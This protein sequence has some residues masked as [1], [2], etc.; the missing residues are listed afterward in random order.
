MYIENL[1]YVIPARGVTPDNLKIKQVVDDFGLKIP[2][3]RQS[4]LVT[5]IAETRKVLLDA[6]DYYQNQQR[7][8]GKL[9][10]S[11]ISYRQDLPKHRKYNGVIYSIIFQG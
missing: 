5:N 3:I 9:Q 1:L 6:V 10:K 8:L 4:E 11:S 2:F 7:Y